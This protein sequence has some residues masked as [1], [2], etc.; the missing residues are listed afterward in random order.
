MTSDCSLPEATIMTAMRTTR[1]VPVT[2]VRLRIMLGTGSSGL[3]PGGELGDRLE[4][5]AAAVG[6]EQVGRLGPEADAAV[7]AHDRVDV[8]GEILPALQG[9]DERLAAQVLPRRLEHGP[10]HLGQAP[11]G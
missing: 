5:P 11:L 9:R 3:E 2:A 1:A 10:D 8:G 6:L 7:V 4:G